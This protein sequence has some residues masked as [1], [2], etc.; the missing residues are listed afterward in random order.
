MLLSLLS[1]NELFPQINIKERVEIAPKGIN[2]PQ[3][4]DPKSE[5][6]VTFTIRGGL[7]AFLHLFVQCGR[8][9]INCGIDPCTMQNSANYF[10][11]P[12]SCVATYN[13]ADWGIYEINLWSGQINTFNVP[14][15]VNVNG[16]P[17]DTIWIVEEPW[18]VTWC[19]YT[20][21]VGEGCYV[22]AK[23]VACAGHF[24]IANYGSN[25][26]SYGEARLISISANDSCGWGDDNPPDTYFHYE[27]LDSSSTYGTLMD[28][29]RVG[30]GSI[31]D[32][33]PMADN[34]AFCAFGKTPTDSGTV[35]IRISA[36]NGL[37]IPA[38]VFLNVLPAKAQAIAGKNYLSPGDT[39]SL[40]FQIQGSDGQWMTKP[41]NWNA[42]YD[43]VQ[44]DSFGFLYKRNITDSATEI[45]NAPGIM[46]FH[47]DNN[48]NV[49]SVVV[50]IQLQAQKQKNIGGGG[51]PPAAIHLNDTVVV[52]TN[53]IMKLNNL[54]L[55]KQGKTSLLQALKKK[56]NLNDLQ[57]KKVKTS[58]SSHGKIDP[59]Q[60]VK[61]M[62]MDE[63]LNLGNIMF[64]CYYNYG[65]DYGLVRLVIKGSSILL[66]ETKYY[67][68]TLDPNNSNNL[69]INETKTPTLGLGGL[70]DVI[71]DDPMAASGNE[72][73]PVYWED[74]YPTYNGTTLTGSNKLPKGMIRLVG[75]YWEQGKTFK[76][77][78]TAHTPDGKSG[79]IDIEVKKPMK[80]IAWNNITGNDKKEFENN[81]Q[82]YSKT[83]DVFGK[84]LNV[85]DL[86]INLAGG[87][88]IPP[89]L[90]KAQMYQEAN[91]D[92]YHFN[93]SYRYE[94]FQDHEWQEYA[95]SSSFKKQPFYITSTFPQGDGPGIPQNHTNLYPKGLNP[96]GY[97]TNSI[98][99]SQYV[100]SNW[101]KYWTINQQL[102]GIDIIGSK[103]LTSLWQSV[104]DKYKNVWMFGINPSDI[105]IDAVKTKIINS[106][107][108][109]YAQTRKVASYGFLQLLYTTAYQMG[110]NNGVSVSS[111]LPPENLN[112][113]A[114][115]IPFYQSFTISKLSKVLQIN[116]G[117]IPDHDWAKGW[118]G[119][120]KLML[121]YY[122]QMTTYPDQVMTE[123][124][125]FEPQ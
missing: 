28:Q 97:P 84:P 78:L 121:P 45:S 34:V 76:T 15:Y 120:W 42:W 113:D 66:G 107:N 75:R 122:N 24:I 46:D 124:L 117:S 116:V 9:G 64:T 63:S 67:Y 43:I 94:P 110:Y 112:D 56:S 47:A 19:G 51:G 60:L 83:K 13:G 92:F 3:S 6:N 49:D 11:S 108:N 85:D 106:Y 89:Q 103:E 123:I 109:M 30:Q 114:T 96:P 65:N 93:P 26:M 61:S 53:K 5:G 81:T 12:D 62:S 25:A 18:P 115:F 27:L 95:N 102:T 52:D 1:I 73:N 40:Q 57:T 8:S 44:A 38:D 36:C 68:A 99:I 31:V 71:F 119:T 100:L 37:M 10:E 80:L 91:K 86:I 48:I 82:D 58:I 50:L 7:T 32:S 14:V 22:S 104:F 33:V 70:S 55:S 72:K 125:F 79:S 105:A 90:I 29:W 16:Q 4:W 54:V 111:A 98:L 23:Y 87:S 69:L 59:R 101:S 77:T 39:T 20:L 35:H 21:N 74:Q 17:K 88:G 118:E 2:I 41:G